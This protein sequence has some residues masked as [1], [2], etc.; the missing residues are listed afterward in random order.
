MLVDEQVTDE[1]ASLFRQLVSLGCR[2]CG[3]HNVGSGPHG[4][5]CTKCRRELQPT[6]IDLVLMGLDWTAD[7]LASAA[8]VSRRTVLRAA[9][10]CPV[11]RRTARKLAKVTGIA[12]ELLQRGVGESHSTPSEDGH[13][14]QATR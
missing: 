14:P 12:P 3:A 5:L 1:V 4:D 13:D 9:T 2:F 6:P 8:Q 7:D 10:G 11:G